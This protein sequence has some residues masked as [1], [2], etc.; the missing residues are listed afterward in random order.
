MVKRQKIKQTKIGM[1]SEELDIDKCMNE[2]IK[3]NLAGIGF[4]L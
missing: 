1:I 4:K 3:M 2:K